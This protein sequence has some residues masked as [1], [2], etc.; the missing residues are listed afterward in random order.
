M[1]DIE[2]VSLKI[3]GR[4]ITL[5]CPVEEKDALVQAA[6]LLNSELEGIDNKSNAL[7]LAGLSLA[8]KFLQNEGSSQTNVDDE[9]KI[10]SM[11]KNIEEVLEN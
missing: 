3:F 4:D 8:N 6:E 1:S 10:Q 5:S 11:L 7:I 2:V 9:L